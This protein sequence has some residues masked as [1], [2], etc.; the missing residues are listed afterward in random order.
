MEASTPMFA[1]SVAVL[2]VVA[3]AL[4]LRLAE[5]RTARIKAQRQPSGDRLERLR[6]QLRQDL[7]G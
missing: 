5:R 3:I 7:R 2:L 1:G 6:Q 4:G